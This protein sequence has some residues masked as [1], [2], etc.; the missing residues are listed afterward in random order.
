MNE[1]NQLSGGG[2][3]QRAST[4][5]HSATTDFAPDVDRLVQGGVARGRTLR[6]RRRVGS[7][8]A[9]VA[10]VGILGVAAGAGT[11]LLGS[12]ATPAPSQYA[13]SPSSGPSP[14][15]PPADPTKRQPIDATLVV[16]AEDAPEVIGGL[17][18]E[19]T[20]EEILRDA[21][22]GVVDEPQRKLVHF[23]YSGTL[24]TFSIEPAASLA[25]CAELVDPADQPDGEP[26]GVCV[27]QDG[28]VLLRSEPTTADGVTAQGVTAFVHG[29]VVSALSYNAPD[30]KDVPTTAPS[31]PLSMDDLTTV[32][33]SEVWFGS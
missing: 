16:T 27:E 15:S 23:R 28:V 1:Q 6:R 19:G 5:L 9:A 24:T 12:Q 3:G 17:A 8:L 14:S 33:T 21:P 10:V 20:V 13:D 2:D 29:Y 4:L 26:G 7:S 32:V 18:G 31:P 25:T 30:G 22:Y 11:G